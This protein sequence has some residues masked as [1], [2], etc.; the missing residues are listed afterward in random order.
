MSSFKGDWLA[1]VEQAWSDSESVKPSTKPAKQKR[2]RVVINYPALYRMLILFA[3][4][5][6]LAVAAATVD[7]SKSEPAHAS[8][9]FAA[10][11]L[12]DK[13]PTKPAKPAGETEQIKA[14]TPALRP[15]QAAL[16]RALSDE[17]GIPFDY[18]KSYRQAARKFKLPWQ[19][20]A[21]IG[22]KESQHG[23][24][25]SAGIHS[26]LNYANC[27][28][29][30]MQLCIVDYPCQNTGNVYARD[31]DG[32]GEFDVYNRD[33]AIMTAASYFAD[34]AQITNSKDP[35]ILLA[36]YNAGPGNVAK[37]GGVPPFAE[38]EDYVAEGMEIAYLLGYEK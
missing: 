23:Q 1:E 26:G 15:S 2:G 19:L 5:A 13:Q 37:Y 10:H 31:G 6:M 11:S 24:S 38:T 16:A 36:A 29:G 30:P 35:A 9:N 7:V 34:L 22:H 27:C 8:A 32:D 18:F 17:A 4:L 21:A 25:Q 33:D 12:P 20:L 3:F 28:A 14:G